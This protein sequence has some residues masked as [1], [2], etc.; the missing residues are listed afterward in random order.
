MR[1]RTSMP[2]LRKAL[3]RDSDTSARPPVLTYP[4]SSLVRKRTFMPI[5]LEEAVHHR[6]GD[7]ADARLGAPEALGVE[8][9]FVARD[10]A[11][12][13]VHAAVHDDIPQA[14]IAPDLDLGKYD[15]TIDPASRFHPH[16]G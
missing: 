4:A 16:A 14:H 11:I 13:N 3:G 8:L 1:M 12:G 6:L 10:K 15:R 9:G 2:R 7:Q 5:R